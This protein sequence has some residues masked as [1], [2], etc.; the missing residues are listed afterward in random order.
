M[1]KYDDDQDSYYSLVWVHHDCVIGIPSAV[2]DPE[3]CAVVFEALSYEGYYT[4]TP[5]LYDTLLL[6]RMAKTE[7]AKRSLEIIFATR[8][9]DPGQYWDEASGFPDKMLRHTATHNSNIASLWE[10]N[11]SATEEQMKEINEFIDATR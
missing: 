10:T 7:E 5:V 3:M 11:R 6:N 1:P 2:A 8:V 4:V 9:Y